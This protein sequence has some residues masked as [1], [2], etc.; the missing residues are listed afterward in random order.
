MSK[1]LEAAKHI[2]KVYEMTNGDLSKMLDVLTKES[3]HL[4]DDDIKAKGIDYADI[5]DAFEDADWED[6]IFS[7]PEE[8]ICFGH[9]TED[10]MLTQKAYLDDFDDDWD[11]DDFDDDY[12]GV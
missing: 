4:T 6:V 5:E 12:Y 11:Y 1:L 3:E 9:P 7:E 10:L 8:K 2:G